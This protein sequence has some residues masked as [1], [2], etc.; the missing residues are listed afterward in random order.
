MNGR[1]AIGDLSVSTEYA[2]PPSTFFSAI[3]PER[4]LS[5]GHRPVAMRT[6]G[7]LIKSSR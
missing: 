1:N 6:T 4:V 2:S 7:S 3:K 5:V